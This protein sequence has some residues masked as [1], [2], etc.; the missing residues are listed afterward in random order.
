M[1][2]T[3]LFIWLPARFVPLCLFGTRIFIAATVCPSILYY[4]D[5]SAGVV[6]LLLPTVA[7]GPP[8]A[9]CVCSAA[10][11]QLSDCS[12]IFVFVHRWGTGSRGLNGVRGQR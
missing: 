3:P 4:D 7:D 1:A 12:P 6:L 5:R 2:A 10:S 11:S 9:V 8:Y